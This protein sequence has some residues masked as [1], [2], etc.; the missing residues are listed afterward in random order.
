MHC[1]LRRDV[2]DTHILI[3]YILS[4]W[5]FVRLWHF[6]FS[7]FFF[8]L[9]QDFGSSSAD[10]SLARLSCHGTE[11]MWFD[12]M[13]SYGD[14]GNFL[15]GFSL[16]GIVL[17]FVTSSDSGSL[18]ID[19]L[20]AN[21]DKDPPR[22]QRVFWALM[23]G[24]TA[25]ALLVAGD[26]DGKYRDAKRVSRGLRCGYRWQSQKGGLLR[27]LLP[28]GLS[29]D[30]STASAR[31]CDKGSVKNGVFIHPASGLTALQTA[32][33]L[34]GLP[35]T[36]I[37]C[38]ICTSIWRAVKVAAGDL[39]PRGPDFEIGLFDPFFAEPWENIWEK[40]SRYSLTV[41]FRGFLVQHNVLLLG[42][43]S[44]LWDSSLIW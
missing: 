36:F 9:G 7:C 32:G 8:S 28:C 33:L 13:R 19:C 38:L 25:T 20:S 43:S 3:V 4:Q 21:G 37:V 18:V 2:A 40:R 5:F 26:K 31:G 41:F 12:V 15:A 1:A 17:Y 27:A 30:L 42:A 16:I 6:G 44:S 29:Y 11:Q 34:S 35:Y 23:E 14:V 24:A 10:R 22:V 39:D